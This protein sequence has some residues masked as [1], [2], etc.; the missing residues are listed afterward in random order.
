MNAIFKR[1]LILLLLCL[2]LWVLPSCSSPAS[3]NQTMDEPTAAVATATHTPTIA[4]V[5][6]STNTP[7]RDDPCK[8]LEGDIE[9]KILVGPASAVGLKPLAVG[10]VPFSVIS[11]AVPFQVEGSGTIDYQNVLAEE[12]GTYTVSMNMEMQISGECVNDSTAPQLNLTITGSGEQLTEINVDGSI[13]QYPRSGTN[14]IEVN[15]PLQVGA[16]SEGEGY[17]FA[18]VQLNR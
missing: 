5:E 2:L 16:I 4:P 15:F 11:E 8:G 3:T 6:I 13:Q 18:L 9:V 1:F 17:T 12:W 14:V 7:A 10:S